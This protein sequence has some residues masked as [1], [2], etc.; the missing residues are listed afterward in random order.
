MTDIKLKRI[1]ELARKSKAEGLTPEEK[2]EQQ[3]LRQEYIAA[4][5]ASTKAQLDSIV[6][7]DEQGNRRKIT[8]K[9]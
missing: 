4:F 1:N 5:R 7:V 2:Q 9:K 8:P 6:L 3:V